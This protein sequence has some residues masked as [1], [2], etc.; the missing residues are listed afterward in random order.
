MCPAQLVNVINAD[1]TITAWCDYVV[2]ENGADLEF[3]FQ[4]TGPLTSAEDTQLESI[5]QTIECVD[6]SSVETQTEALQFVEDL[7]WSQTSTRWYQRKLRLTT[8]D[9]SSG[10]Y[11]IGWSYRYHSDKTS[12]DFKARVQLNDAVDLFLHRQEPTDKQNDQGYRASGFCY[13]SLSGINDIDLGFCSSS[14]SSTAHICEARMEIWKVGSDASYTPGNVPGD[15]PDGGGWW[16]WDWDD[17]DDDD[18][19]D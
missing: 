17:D 7:P 18:D 8:N 16:D 19:D 5:L 12:R 4:G 14:S 10:L 11:R 6:N 15:H 9:L 3:S 1:P 2:V 13:Y